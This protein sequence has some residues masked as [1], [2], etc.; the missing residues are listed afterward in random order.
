M[1]SVKPEY[2]MFGSFRRPSK[3]VV[4]LQ[5]PFTGARV[6]LRFYVIQK[7]DAKLIVPFD[8]VYQSLH[9]LN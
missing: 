1:T 6:P 4:M 5:Y 2:G 9:L 8:P 3:E 7:Q